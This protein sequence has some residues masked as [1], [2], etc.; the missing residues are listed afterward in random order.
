MVMPRSRSR[1][2][3]SRNCSF[4]SRLESAPV[5]SRSLSARVDLPWSMCAMMQ[6]LRIEAASV[7]L[8]PAT[9]RVA[10]IAEGPIQTLGELDLGLPAQ[11]RRGTPRRNDRAQLLAGTRRGILRRLGFAGDPSQRGVQPV[12]A[13]LSAGADVER[14]TR[15][16]RRERVEIGAHHV[17]HIG[18]VAGL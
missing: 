10:K 18:I 9:A 16:L 17:A 14:E 3:E 13:G 8:T 2:M 6:K 11:L 5:R 7:M 12:D 1:S 15:G 4:S